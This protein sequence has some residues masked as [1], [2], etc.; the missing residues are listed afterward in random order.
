MSMPGFNFKRAYL[1]ARRDFLGY[2]RTWGFW[3]TTFGPLLMI[4]FIVIAPI[5][6][7]KSEPTRYATIL[8]ETGVHGVAIERLAQTENDRLME[9]AVKEISKLTVSQENKEEFEKVLREQ[10]TDAAIAYIKEKSP[11]VCLLYTSPSPRDRQKSRMP[12]SA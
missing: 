9:A 2:V 6:M 12:S 7:S 10:G 5:V 3:L 8:D 1:I 11:N 4:A